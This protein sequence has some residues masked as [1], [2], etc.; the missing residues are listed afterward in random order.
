MVFALFLAGL[1]YSG[2]FERVKLFVSGLAESGLLRAGVTLQEVRIKGQ[3]SLSDA[4]IIKALGIRTGQSLA[5]FDAHQAQ[6]RLSAL[7]QVKTA[8]V[9]RLFPSTILVDITERQPFVRWLHD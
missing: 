8:R 3:L 1:F 5:G 7:G 2:F 6:R 4:Q 9:M